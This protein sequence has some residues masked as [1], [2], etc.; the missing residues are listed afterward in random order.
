M[1]HNWNVALKFKFQA[2]V[3]CH[4]FGASDLDGFFQNVS[5]Y[6][7]KRNLYTGTSK[8]C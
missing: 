3:G 1:T 6:P 4:N 8:H 2:F 7:E 5:R